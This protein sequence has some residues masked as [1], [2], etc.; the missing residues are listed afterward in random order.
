[1]TKKNKIYF[2]EFEEEQFLKF[3]N[4]DND[5]ERNKI[6]SR[7]LHEP[8]KRMI[9]LVLKSLVSINPSIETFDTLEEC[10]NFVSEQNKNYTMNVKKHNKNENQFLQLDL[11]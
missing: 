7:Y 2:G 3:I 1:M 11:F 10:F 6:Y 8:F 9:N 5:F 4:E